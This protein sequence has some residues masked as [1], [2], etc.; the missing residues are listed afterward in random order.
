MRGE[1]WINSAP[2]HL[3]LY[4]SFG[5]TAPQLIHLPLLRNPDKSKLSK[6]K[7]PTSILHYQ[8]MGYLPEAVVNYLGRMAWSMPDES[9]KFS[10]EAMLEHFDLKRISL[11]GPIF[12]VGKLAWLNGCWIREELSDDEFADRVTQWAMNRDYLKQVIPLV[13][14]RVNTWSELVGMAGFFLSGTPGLDRDALTFK[15]LDEETTRRIYAYAA[16][17]LDAQA[18]WNAANI[19]G[20]LRHLAAVMELKLRVLLAPFFLAIAGQRS[21]T[22]LFQTMAILGRDLSRA[23]LRNAL[24]TLGPLSGKEQKKWRK[25][26]DRA[27]LD[28][29]QRVEATASAEGPTASPAG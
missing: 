21:A 15:G 7:N 24:D 18:D 23:R 29:A 14:P 4:A 8:R 20:A 10:L 12:D 27:L 19:E 17:T 26:Y 16:W 13:R 5:W 9:E 25:A 6:R 11:G 3:P 28:H 2:K 1:E 22:P